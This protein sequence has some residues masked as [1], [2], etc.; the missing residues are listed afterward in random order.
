[1]PMQPPFPGSPGKPDRR[2]CPN[3]RGNC[4]APCR[5]SF[6]VAGACPIPMQP[7]QPRLMQP[8]AGRQQG[9]HVAIA[10]EILEDLP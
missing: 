9:E 6:P 8:D 10:D 3:G 2:V 4:A 7:L 1:M 5:L